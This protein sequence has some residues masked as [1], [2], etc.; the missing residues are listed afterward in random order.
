MSAEMK[1]GTY[2]GP[3]PHLIGEGALLR[4]TAEGKVLAQFDDPNLTWSGNPIKKLT[5]LVYEPHA[6]F[7]TEQQVDHPGPPPDA[8]GYGWHE[9]S[10]EHFEEDP[11]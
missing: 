1:H 2:R 4:K 8:L 10:P 6:R 7:P 9:F 5:V 3:I 11:R